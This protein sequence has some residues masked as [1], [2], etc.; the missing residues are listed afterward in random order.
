MISTYGQAEV[1]QPCYPGQ[2]A[3]PQMR[4]AWGMLFERG[5]V[6]KWLTGLPRSFGL[7]L[8]SS[9]QEKPEARG[10]APK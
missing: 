1:K 9:C 8:R 6:L 10:M 5:K 3:T 7:T 4:Y 2:Q